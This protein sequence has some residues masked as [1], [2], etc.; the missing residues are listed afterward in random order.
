MLRLVTLLIITA[1]I[2]GC[3][4]APIMSCNGDFCKRNGY[5]INDNGSY[6]NG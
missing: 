5:V 1:L 4:D 6:T 3:D 2:C